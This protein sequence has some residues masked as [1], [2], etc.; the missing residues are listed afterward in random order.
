MAARNKFIAEAGAEELKIVLG[1]KINFRTLKI[2]LPENKYIA[3][4]ADFQQMIDSKRAESKKLES[5]IGR[6]VH[7]SQILPQ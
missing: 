7:V 4:T 2:F 6:M 5:C 1:W 3:W